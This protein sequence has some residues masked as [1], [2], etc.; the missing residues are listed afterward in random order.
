MRIALTTLSLLAGFGLAACANNPNRPTD[1]GSMQEPAPRAS[2]NYGTET[3]QVQNGSMA[4]NT[5]FGG[6]TTRG[7]TAP[8]TGSMALP[9]RAQGNSTPGRY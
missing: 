2:G 7:A 6:V 1:V 9:S 5:P 8:D 3:P 4:P